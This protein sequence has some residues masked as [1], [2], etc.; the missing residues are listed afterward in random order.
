MPD[1]WAE[2]GGGMA[3]E[4]ASGVAKGTYNKAGKREENTTWC[5]CCMDYSSTSVYVLHV[6]RG[7]GVR[8]CPPGLPPPPAAKFL[9]SPA[10]LRPLLLTS[11]PSL[12]LLFPLLFPIFPL[13][14][15]TLSGELH[16][17][18]GGTWGGPCRKPDSRRLYGGV[19]V[20]R[21][22]THTHTHTHTRAA[23]V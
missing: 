12:P 6:S 19:F 22:M 14:S 11:T 1:F 21:A 3:S 20:R 5:A 8:V 16:P 7:R 2:V 13:P 23:G 9:S 4:A 18:P 15:C 17:S 10:L